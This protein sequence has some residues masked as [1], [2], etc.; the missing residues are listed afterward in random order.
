MLS[1]KRENRL[2]NKA[3]F[4]RV[5]KSGIRSENDLFTVV[6]VI[7]SQGR[8][9]LGISIPKKYIS[10]A[11]DRN[12]VRRVIRETLRNSIMP[13]HGIDVVIQIRKRIFRIDKKIIADLINLELALLNKRLNM[14][15]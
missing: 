11:I 3:D 5:F 4:S 15:C 7:A 14:Q 6:Y 12:T 8:F 9:R 13:L 10:L 1:I 2:K